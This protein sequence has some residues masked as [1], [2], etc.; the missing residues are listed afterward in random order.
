[1]LHIGAGC[2]NMSVT[3]YS[4]IF[5]IRTATL[6]QFSKT[7][8]LGVLSPD[9][10]LWLDFLFGISILAQEEHLKSTDNPNSEQEQKTEKGPR[11]QHLN[12]NHGCQR[13]QADDDVA[14]P[15]M[16]HSSKETGHDSNIA[17]RAQNQHLIQVS[18]RFFSLISISGNMFSA[19]IITR[20]PHYL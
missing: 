7:R 18:T 11:N 19:V 15:E 3:K 10:N 16:I 13:W 14:S 9:W 5:P 4:N 2:T 17:E 6:F 20:I 12:I 1:M 8:K